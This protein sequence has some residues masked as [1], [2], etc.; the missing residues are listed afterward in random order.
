M[1]TAY[2]WEKIF[3]RTELA[4]KHLLEKLQFTFLF[5]FSYLALKI[6]KLVSLDRII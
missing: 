3:V 2:F 1:K 5:A 4:T 6:T